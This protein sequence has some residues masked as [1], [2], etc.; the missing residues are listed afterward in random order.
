MTN[1]F[2]PAFARQYDSHLKHLKLKGLQP[3]TIDAYARAIRRLGGYFDYRIEALSE[4]QLTEYFSD[5]I[6]THSW[7]AVKLDLYGLKFFTVHVLKKIWAT[8][9]LI[10]PP[11]SQR[12]PDI[13]TV[14]ETADYART[15]WYEGTA[16]TGAARFLSTP[17]IVGVGGG[18]LPVIDDVDAD[19][20]TDIV[21]PQYFIGGPAFIWFERTADPSLANPAGVWVQHNFAATDTVKGF[22]IEKIPNLL[23]DGVARWVGTNHV[24]TTFG[25]TAEAALW[26]FTEG[27]T[28]T[29]PRLAAPI[30]TGIFARPSSPTSLAPGLFGSGDVDSDGDIDFVV[31]GDGDDR[32]FVI[33]QG[34]G[35]TFTTYKLASGMGQAGGGEV[36]DLDND[37]HREALFTS[38]EKG[39]VKL[40]EF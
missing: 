35:G 13:V 18:S 9:N 26:K 15:E 29:D 27:V 1:N 5:L 14:G 40:Y 28:P 17:H 39:V 20:D 6:G 24:N 32:L 11:K 36:T 19:G 3:K 22:E 8:P 38:Y 4:A 30:S 33:L 23:G 12:L 16:G 10:K 2:P 25:S 34:P 7:S 31:S 37:G 21:S